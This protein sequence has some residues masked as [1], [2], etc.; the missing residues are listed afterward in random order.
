MVMKKGQNWI[1]LP[2]AKSQQSNPIHLAMEMSATQLDKM[3]KKEE[4]ERAFLGIILLVKEDLEGMETLDESVTMVKPK[5]DEALPSDICAILE[6]Y[7]DV[8]PRDVP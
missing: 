3:L 7:D 2:L 1:S 6:E 5:W 4:V 8:F